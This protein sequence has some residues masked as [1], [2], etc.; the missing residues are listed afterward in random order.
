VETPWPAAKSSSSW[1]SAPKVNLFLPHDLDYVREPIYSLAAAKTIERRLVMRRQL[2]R[3]TM[4]ASVAS[5]GAPTPSMA[6]TVAVVAEAPPPGDGLG[7]E[8]LVQRR[9]RGLEM[10]ARFW[11][12]KG[13]PGGVYIGERCCV[14]QRDSK[15]DFISNLILSSMIIGRIGKG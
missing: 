3:S 5:G 11:G 10:A 15:A 2:G 7:R 14:I 9:R 1:H 13:P 12:L 6:P 8:A 4:V